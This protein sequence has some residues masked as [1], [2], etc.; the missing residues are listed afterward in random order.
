MR[1]IKLQLN[2][3]KNKVG[4]TVETQ[5]IV[6]QNLNSDDYF[7]NNSDNE[8]EAPFADL[9]NWEL[10]DMVAAMEPQIL[11]F[12]HRYD[13]LDRENDELQMAN[14]CFVESLEKVEKDLQETKKAHDKLKCDYDKLEN[15]SKELEKASDKLVQENDK[16]KSDVQFYKDRFKQE[17]KKCDEKSKESEKCKSELQKVERKLEKAEKNTVYACKILNVEHRDGK[18]MCFVKT[19]I[20]RRWISRSQLPPNFSN[21]NKHIL[22][23]CQNPY[24]VYQISEIVYSYNA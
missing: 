7:Q 21:E 22:G 23:Q 1:K 3:S 14:E 20:D 13:Q 2:E 4:K 15:S 18:M 11:S 24:F 6:E 12:Q 16:I 17:Q 9:A 10:S 19:N 8:Y 5:T